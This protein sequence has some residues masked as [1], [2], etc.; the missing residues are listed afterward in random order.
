MT[1]TSPWATLL[2]R[3]EYSAGDNYLPVGESVLV[4]SSI[5]S[6]IERDAFAGLK[7]SV[8]IPASNI[9]APIR[10]VAGILRADNPNFPNLGIGT[11]IFKDR[12]S[13][14]LADFVGPVAIAE[15]PRD[16]DAEGVDEDPAVSFINLS[17]GVF[18]EFRIQL[19]DNGD[20]SDPFA[21]IG[22]DDTT[23]VVPRIPGIRS[24]GANITLFENERLLVEGIDYTFNFDETKKII[25]L[26]PLAGI[27]KSDR[28]YQIAL[29]NR[30]RT[31]LV[32]PDPSRLDDGDQLE[33]TD[34]SGG[35][36][37]FEFESGFQL[38]VPEPITLVVPNIGT[39]AGGLNDGDI[40]QI[41]DGQNPTVVFEFN[42][43]IATLPGTV[44][45]PLPTGP[46]PTDDAELAAFLN[47]IA[48]DMQ[49]AIQGEI[50]AG[51]LNADVR[52]IDNEVVVGTER[53]ATAR[54]TGS[55]LLQ[56]PR[57]LGLNVPAAGT[58]IGGVAA[59]ETF[60]VSNGILSVTFEFNDG[61]TPVTPGSVGVDITEPVDPNDPT[62]LT[63]IPLTADEVS[64]A[65]VDAIAGTQLE[66]NPEILGRTVY[67]N[68]PL[69]G[70]ATVP[71]GQL[72]VVGVSRTP[73]DGDTIVFTP[74]DG[75][76]DVVL[77][78]NRTDEPINGVPIDDG[79]TD[80]NIPINIDRAMT[81]D[82]FAALI[83]SGIR[84]QVISGLNPN[85]VQVIAGGLVTIGGQQ[86][87]GL[88]VTGTSLEIVGSPD[89]TGASTIEVFGPL[90]LN[91]PVV[92][93]GGV[94][95]GSVLIISDDLG[96]DVFFE[97]DF[98]GNINLA[99][100]IP[101]FTTRLT[102]STR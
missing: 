63:T 78:I 74:T 102:M 58:D 39:N 11:S 57:T 70:S 44:Q 54:T 21:G 32:A 13:N 87:L 72:T 43:D 8:G 1:S 49:T 35:T 33:I 95:D 31:A 40:F 90:L 69:A 5:N 89:V 24:P 23:V 17:S 79:V 41:N 55:G 46:T 60:E 12:G 77:E 93:G 62:G 91:M 80:P 4:D 29:N 25:T 81:A 98:D 50:D 14:E 84:S 99:N 75:T 18:E 53:G 30:D 42:S 10:D 88:A 94:Q 20:A 100:S 48:L 67:L 52:V 71:G 34:T 28:A 73:N 22:I 36:V 97:F 61:T 15:I 85:D 6:L 37:V 19:R 27:W 64:L 76:A 51:R 16:N 7:N 65:I 68:L 92:G 47:G 3:L 9:L 83:S 86:G 26:T 38:L 59:R 96:N 82:E 2:R 66:L 101:S 56:L 45:V